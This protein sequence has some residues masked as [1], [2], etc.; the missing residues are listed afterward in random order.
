MTQTP[1]FTQPPWVIGSQKEEMAWI[2]A[3]HPSKKGRN[4]RSRPQQKYLRNLRIQ[5]DFNVPYTNKGPTTAWSK[6][7]R[8]LTRTSLVEEGFDLI[9]TIEVLLRGLTK[10][11]FRYLETLT[12]DKTPFEPFPDATHDI[13]KTIDALE[14]YSG[15]KPSG[16]IVEIKANM[17]QGKK[18][19][20]TITLKKIHT[21]KEHSVNIQIKGGIPEELYHEFRNYLDKKLGV[22]ELE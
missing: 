13:R 3:T 21:T 7:M 1:E 11:K 18:C 17:P 9:P 8:K 22:K 19:R 12:I 4:N 15:D 14:H 5:F 10:I 2:E 20:A 16:T 6:M